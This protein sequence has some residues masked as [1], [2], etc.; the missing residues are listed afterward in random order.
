[1]GQIVQKYGR[2]TGL[3]KGRVTGINVTVMVSYG[4]GMVATFVDQIIIE[5]I[6]GRAI[7]QAGDSGSL[8]VILGG[9]DDR[10]PVGLMFAG[11]SNGSLAVANPIDAVLSQFGVTIDGE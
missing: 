3:T 2:T 8:A 6:K 9:D 5:K 1:L 10:K 4:T 11:N 7:I